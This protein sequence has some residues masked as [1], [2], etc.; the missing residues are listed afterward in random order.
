MKLQYCQIEGGNFGDDL[1]RLLWPSLF[2]DLAQQA[3]GTVFY[4]IGTLLDGHHAK[5]LKKVV[6]GTGIGEARAARRDTNWDFRWVRGPH[7]AREFGIPERFGLG[8]S[9]ILWPELQRRKTQVCAEGPIG[10]IPHY[11]TWDSFDWNQV[12]AQAGMVAIN[13]R[14][15]PQVVVARM[16]GCSRIMAESLHG[17]ICADAMGI[18]W[19]ASVLAHRFNAFKWLDWLATINRPFAPFVT[20]RALVSCITPTKALANRLARSVS[21]LKHTRHPALRPVAPA[22]D[23]DASL[24]ARAL[25]RFSREESH[26]KCSDA[27]ALNQQQERMLTRCAKFARDYGLRFEPEPP[28]LTLPEL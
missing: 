4:G 23:E 11:A 27:T 25:Y 26:F 10:L 16:R 5:R 7:S 9:A 28:S 12:A 20:D 1:N 2:P 13:P 24:V 21:Y 22:S 17:A 3:V 6:L 14:L 18:P 19:A 15:A 8:D